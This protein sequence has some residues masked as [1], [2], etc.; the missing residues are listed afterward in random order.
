MAHAFFGH[1]ELMTGKS[2]PLSPAP[3]NQS[4][5]S[6]KDDDRI[7]GFAKLGTILVPVR[8]AEKVAERALRSF[9]TK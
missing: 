7:T 1:T 3:V 9:G 8:D 4:L 2:G 5:P 6:S